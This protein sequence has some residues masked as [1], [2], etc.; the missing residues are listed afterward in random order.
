MA[1]RRVVGEGNTTKAIRFW[2]GD[3]SDADFR[4]LHE[5][6]RTL[7]D[8]HRHFTQA[9][10]EYV[11]A[12]DR[13]E[14]PEVIAQTGRNKGNP[15]TDPRQAYA[16]RAFQEQ[17][18]QSRFVKRFGNTYVGEIANKD[19]KRQ[20]GLI[21]TGQK[22]SVSFGPGGHA[23]IDVL[24]EG[25]Q[26]TIEHDDA[27]WWLCGLGITLDDH[28]ERPAR[29]WA[30]IPQTNGGAA[31]K[32][33]QASRTLR[34]MD[35]A[36]RM[37]RVRLVWQD[38][39]RTGGRK[40]WEAQVCCTM[41]VVAGKPSEPT[42]CGVDV[43]MRCLLVASIPSAKKAQ[44]VAGNSYGKIWDEIKRQ[45]KRRAILYKDHK[46][47]ASAA[48]SNKASRLRK[49]ACELASRQLID[50][51]MYHHVATIRIEDLSGIRDRCSEEGKTEQDRTWNARLSHWPWYYLQQ[52]IE[53]KA[54]E[55]GIGVEKVNPHL[56]SQT[57]S[58]CGYVAAG[59]RS[60]RQ[61]VCLRCGFE[62]HADLN[63]ANNIAGRDPATDF[64]T[65]DRAAVR[66]D[67]PKSR[68]KA[69]RSG[70]IVPSDNPVTPR[71]DVLQL[72]MVL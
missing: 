56:T 14:A 41:P 48:H 53:Q 44:F 25:V 35:Q 71:H 2:L 72:D 15:S 8:C 29:R 33:K 47:H 38:G 58:K 52:R 28:A 32:A 63:A 42:I 65:P 24:T 66:S 16:K 21:R 61:F 68:P 10:L 70:R 59:N 3:V 49:H 9:S 26:A 5:L 13:G 69:G 11:F 57:C 1:R 18:G 62:C 19:F 30:L 27:G 55:Y 6:S 54:A 50:W 39:K 40:G 45:G 60:G 51:C 67:G 31:V 36:T 12:D 46:R 64:D 23:N 4:L 20:M 7:S 34:Q 37:S 22:S 43:G 17:F